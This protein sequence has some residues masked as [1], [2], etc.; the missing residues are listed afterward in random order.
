M[1]TQ[2]KLLK[3]TPEQFEHLVADLWQAMGFSVQRTGGPGDEG[4]DIVAVMNRGVRIRMYIQAKCYA[5]TNKV[6]VRE[7]REYASLLMRP[8]TDVIVVVC[9]SGFTESAL[10]EAKKLKVRTIDGGKL[11]QLLNQYN[12]PIERYVPDAKDVYHDAQSISQD[13]QKN[14]K[15]MKSGEKYLDLESIDDLHGKML[16]EIALVIFGLIC[17]KIANNVNILWVYIVCYAGGA[18]LIFKGLLG[19]YNVIKN[20]RRKI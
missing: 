1:W 11:I 2:E 3:L 15:T 9:T 4:V 7:I 14:S 6:G 18:L 13:T 10:E 20:Y 17:F 19:T 16:F 5:P 12:I 8:E